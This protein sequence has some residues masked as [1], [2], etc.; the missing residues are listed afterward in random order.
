MAVTALLVEVLHVQYLVANT[1]AAALLLCANFAVH[2]S[3]TFR[4][5]S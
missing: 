4:P 1:L 3:W 2:S 5:R